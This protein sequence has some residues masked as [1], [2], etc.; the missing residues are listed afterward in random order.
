MAHLTLTLTQTA[1]ADAV[2]D[3]AAVDDTAVDAHSSNGTDDYDNPS[4]SV[5]VEAGD[6]TAMVSVPINDDGV[7][8]GSE[9]LDV[10]VTPPASGQFHNNGVADEATVTI[11]DDDTY[12]V[13]VNSG[14][15][16]EGTPEQV[17][18]TVTGTTQ[19]NVAVSLGIA[20][21]SS[22]GSDKA[23]ASDFTPVSSAFTWTVPAATLTGAT[24]N[25]TV[26]SLDNDTVDEAT[27][28]VVV[29][30]DGAARVT[31]GRGVIRIID[32]DAAATVRISNKKVNERVGRAR[33][34]V[35]LTYRGGTTSTE[36]GV[37]VRYRTVE[38]TAR[39]RS[40]YVARSGSLLFTGTQVYKTVGV[41]IIN[42]RLDEPRYERFAVH[43]RTITPSR[44]RKTDAHGVVR[45]TDND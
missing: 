2:F 22:G 45:I 36:H 1:A 16:S 40:D 8:E 43:L 24:L 14:S 4:D 44:V 12:F 41:R 35:W 30:G 31:V 21:A 38:G 29:S 26:L 9:T 11:D 34:G 13:T 33:V 17:T 28:T 39:A 32:T 27:E 7:Y 19:S 15:G 3:V 42:D 37:R 6:T 18:A 25:V 10:T 5:T 20:G 23:E